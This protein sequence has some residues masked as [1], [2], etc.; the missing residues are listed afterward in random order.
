MNLV[1]VILPTCDRP[2]LLPRA[3]RSVLKQS[4]VALEVLLVDSNRTTGPVLKNPALADMLDDPRVKLIV[5][6]PHPA[7][8][9]QARNAGLDAAQGA[10]IS[11]LDDDDAYLPGK[12]ARQLECAER[13][14]V[15]LVICGYE[16]VMRRRRR[17]RQCH[18]DEYRGDACLVGADYPTPVMFH[19]A[20]PAVRFETTAV[21]AQDHLFA[22]TFLARR[23]ELRVACVPEKL[24]VMHTHEGPRVNSGNRLAVWHEYRFCVQCHGHLFSREARRA[25][26]ATGLLARAQALEVS[27]PEYIRCLRRIGATQGWGSWRLVVNAIARRSSWLSRWVVT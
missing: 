9:S 18:Q 27:W 23:G 20:D 14:G 24:L 16:V 1:S 19:R 15:D 13:S 26:L 25:F 17:V 12:L 2:D 3:L 22:I 6:D 4:G 8:A 11:Y 7:N 21:A 5:P 10:W